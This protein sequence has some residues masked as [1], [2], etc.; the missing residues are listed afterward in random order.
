[1]RPRRLLAWLAALTLSVALGAPTA[2]FATLTTTTHFDFTES[3][4]A[5]NPC[6]GAPGTLTIALSGV[7][8]T[9]EL[10]DGAI[11]ST[12]TTT[13]TVI[14]I[15]DDPSQASFAG[16]LAES[17]G[18]HTNSRNATATNAEAVI[19]HGSDGS[20]GQQRIL[21]HHTVNANGTGPPPSRSPSSPVWRSRATQ[22]GQG[23][24][25]GEAAVA[26][27]TGGTPT[28]LSLI[29]I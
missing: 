12:V 16:H 4:A 2:A 9:T 26:A 14:F 10:D 19:V 29:H 25:A 28:H 13:G 5:V 3:R 8:H 17:D 11:H 23:A 20:L 24:K 6:S 1:M 22:R 21:T 27:V 18:Q 7:L 15:P